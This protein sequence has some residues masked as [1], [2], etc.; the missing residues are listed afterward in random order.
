MLRTSLTLDVCPKLLP[1]CRYSSSY[2]HLPIHHHL[3]HLSCQVTP[4]IFWKAPCWFVRISIHSYPF[5]IFFFQLINVTSQKTPLPHL[6]LPEKK[7]APGSVKLLLKT[8]GEPVINNAYGIPQLRTWNMGANLDSTSRDGWIS[9]QKVRS[10]TLFGD[11]R[12]FLWHFENYP[13][14]NFK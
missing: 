6:V 5:L 11:W 13:L 2:L 9:Q 12:V 1:N 8:T 3:Q 4:R 14:K 7:T 10:E